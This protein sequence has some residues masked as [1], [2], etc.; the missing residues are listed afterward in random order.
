MEP[1]ETLVNEAARGNHGAFKKLYDLHVDGLFRFMRQFSTETDEVE[2][3][4]QRAF[5]KS[6]AN[7]HAFRRDAKFSTWLFTIALNEMRSDR[8]RSAHVTVPLDDG[9]SNSAAVSSIDED[10]SWNDLMKGW[11]AELEETRRA[12]FIL[13]EVEGYSHA[14]IATMLGIGEVTCR[15]HVFRAKKFL[16]DKWKKEQGLSV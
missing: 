13:F 14:E 11:L 3:W 7:L 4:V 2:D 5:V 12:V 6:H 15:S 10:F 1:E 9:L 8:R 16:Q